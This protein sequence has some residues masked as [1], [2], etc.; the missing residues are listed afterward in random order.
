MTSV[1]T[2]VADLLE[3]SNQN[4]IT[5][6]HT[7]HTLCPVHGTY[8][9]DCVKLTIAEE[10]RIKNMSEKHLFR[11][12]NPDLTYCQRFVTRRSQER[13][14][15]VINL[16][17]RMYHKPERVE[18][19]TQTSE[20]GKNPS[21]KQ[22]TTVTQKKRKRRDRGPRRRVK[23]R[24]KIKKMGY[25]KFRIFR[26]QKDFARRMKKAA[27]RTGI[28]ND[29]YFRG[30]GKDGF[31]RKKKFDPLDK[32]KSRSTRDRF[33]T[34]MSE[35][36][37]RSRT[38]NTGFKKPSISIEEHNRRIFEKLGM[39][40]GSTAKLRPDVPRY[41][42]ASTSTPKLNREQPVVYEDEDFSHKVYEPKKPK[43]AIK[44]PQPNRRKNTFA[45][46]EEA[47]IDYSPPLSS[48]FK[49]PEQLESERDSLVI[50]TKDADK[51][52]TN[53]VSVVSSL[54][55]KSL[56]FVDELPRRL[57]LPRFPG[58]AEVKV[59][60]VS[61]VECPKSFS[62]KKSGLAT[63][64]LTSGTVEL[65]HQT[66]PSLTAGQSL[67]RI[68]DGISVCSDDIIM[69]N[70]NRRIGFV[71]IPSGEGKTT[72]SRR[73][74]TYYDHDDLLEQDQHTRYFQESLDG[75]VLSARQLARFQ[76]APLHKVNGILFTWAPSSVNGQIGDLLCGDMFSFGIY[77]LREGNNIRQNAGN[78]RYLETYYSQY[79]RYFDSYAHRD[80]QIMNDINTLFTCV[81]C[82]RSS[83]VHQF[84]NSSMRMQT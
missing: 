21:K 73:H 83:E 19:T 3:R 9:K 79:I 22:K 68:M 51:V 43:I 53:S 29:Y 65:N 78:R 59:E 47:K 64:I 55:K 1:M 62:G 7:T 75:T 13:T 18:Q 17:K 25:R 57:R 61:S 69:K 4:Q 71:C 16:P 48:M 38:D 41:D 45:E 56:S 82:G 66:K 76:R 28:P 42:E 24:R 49:S 8:E 70:P 54:F 72:L 46:R 11:Y 35:E 58:F 60:P 44:R 31:G 30:T 10:N 84:D 14:R 74:V 67:S 15:S 52:L 80:A 63:S 81:L 32:G 34:P 27:I 6:H 77:M 12:R 39:Y 26:N 33:F 50:L 36:S 23:S 5:S 40:E 2:G 20:K 37:F